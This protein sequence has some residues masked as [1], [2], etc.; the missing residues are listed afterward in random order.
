VTDAVYR[1]VMTAMH[2]GDS[3]ISQC[4][5]EFVRVTDRPVPEKV[6]LKHCPELL[7]GGRT[8]AGVPV[9]VQI[10]GGRPEPIVE[11][12]LGAVERGALGID[13]N[14]GCPAQ[15]VNRHDG[16]ASLLRTPC[17]IEDIVARV[18]EA[19]PARVPVSAKIR[20]GWDDACAVGEL[21][22]AAEAGG[23]DWLTVHGRTRQDGYTPPADWTAIGRA[24]AA[25]AIPVVANGDLNSASAL[26]ACAGESGCTAFMIGRGAMGDPELFR[27]CRGQGPAAFDMAH[28]LLLLA[29]YAARML[30]A[31]AAERSALNRLKQWLAYGSRANP[32]LSA[33]FELIKRLDALDEALERLTRP[34]SAVSWLRPEHSAGMPSP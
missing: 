34:S 28:L 20:T 24:R 32:A 13:L 22:R 21:A 30:A 18:R 29:A 1:D 27:R 5:S 2:G 8:P 19:L 15:T 11:T 12:A 4:T 14:F 10:L 17:R 6:L 25:V 3:G 33:P 23:A 26:T 7:H 31:G 16:G 9:F